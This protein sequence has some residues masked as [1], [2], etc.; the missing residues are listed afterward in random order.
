VTDS[1]PPEDPRDALI[2]EQAAR[3]AAQD[4]L[5]AGHGERVAELTALV[6]E[7]RGQLEAA[8]RA[9]SRNSGN[10]SMPPGADDLPGRRPPARKERRAAER[11]E[12]K[13]KPGKQPGAPGAA[14][15]WRR[16]D[17]VTGH[18]PQGDCACGADLAD[19]ADLGV[20][21]S[22]QQE[23]I[24]E[25]Q[26]SRRYQHDL[27]KTR[28]ACGRVHVAPRPAGVPDA[29][30]S[31]GPRLS[32]MAVY[33]SVFQHVP[34][35]RAQLLIADLTGGVVSAGFVHSCLG[36][37]AGLV[38]DAVALI[39]TLIAAAPVAGFDETTLRSGPA[40]EKKYVHG[41]FTE[42]YSAFH[43]GTRGLETMREAGIL[44]SFAGIVV[45]DRYRGYYSETWQGF[46]GH[47][48]CAAHLIRDFQ[49]CAETYPGAPW[50][51]QAMRS[52]RGLIHAWHAARE[53][54]LP[55][56]PAEDR[57]PLETEFRRAVTVGLA[58]VSRVPGPKNKVKQQPGRE[59][60]EFCRD[61]QADVLRF[62]TDTSVWP[63]NNI[64]ERGV[65]PLKTQ[66]KI[67]GR[68]TSDDVTQDRLDIR[69]YIDTARKHGRNAYEILHQ[70][71]T[72]NSW[73]PPAQ[74]ISP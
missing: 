58:A 41:A 54:G 68:L 65:R 13:R 49:D 59:M 27:H 50:P 30:L 44:P 46:A 52:L 2:R 15:R 25:P 16:A 22:Y 4:E 72:G 36:K 24:P 53:Q 63:T 70:L 21:R 64:S 33:L 55:A 7:L 43:L 17:E 39:R 45:S 28:C 26:P 56:I 29:P 61:R 62:A 9:A 23:D 48:A 69:G 66:Q 32:A 42:L 11:A 6:A 38:T 34:V 3:L 47:Q 74:P 57:E 73:L 20:A 31:I 40:G 18:F 5:I 14:M 71:M 10:S 8:L 1:L 60:L 35:E 37:A 19:A 51:G 67:S 12:R